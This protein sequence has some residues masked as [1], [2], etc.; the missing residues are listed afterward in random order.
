MN[1]ENPKHLN[2]KRRS[3]SKPGIITLFETACFAEIDS[4]SSPFTDDAKI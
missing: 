4:E 2:Y 3:K 1:I